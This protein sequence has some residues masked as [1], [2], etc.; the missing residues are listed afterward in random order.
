[1]VVLRKFPKIKI[2]IDHEKCTV[3]FLCK[4]CV[5]ICPTA[6]IHVGRAPGK[7]E[8]LKE[9]DPRIPGNYLLSASRGDRCTV[10]NKCIEVCPVDALK[11]VVG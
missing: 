4:K 1:M 10:C 3:P 11:I 7:E 6:I 5:Q 8:R 2:T 9:T